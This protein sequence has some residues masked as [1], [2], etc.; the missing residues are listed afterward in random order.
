MWKVLFQPDRSFCYLEISINSGS[1]SWNHSAMTLTVVCFGKTETTQSRYH[2]SDVTPGWTNPYSVK[3][4]LDSWR[5][6][7]QMPR[8]SDTRWV[9]PLCMKNRPTSIKTDTLK[10]RQRRELCVAG[11][12]LNVSDKV[13][14]FHALTQGP[15]IQQEP[16]QRRQIWEQRKKKT[17]FEDVDSDRLLGKNSSRAHVTQ[18]VLFGSSFCPLRGSSHTV[19]SHVLLGFL[20]GRSSW[21]QALGCLLGLLWSV[22]HWVPEQ[23]LGCLSCEPG[24]RHGTE[25]FYGFL[26]FEQRRCLTSVMI[27]FCGGLTKGGLSFSACFFFISLCLRADKKL[28]FMLLCVS[29]WIHSICQDGGWKEADSWYDSWC[30]RTKCFINPSAPL[31]QQKWWKKM[32][33][34][35][36]RM[37]D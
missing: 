4:L 8:G 32:Q 34:T 20:R 33:R 24:D 7:V 22:L 18:K 30:G 26:M 21:R 6:W 3:M 2:W 17:Q 15:E 23:P 9:L 37:P 13:G 27:F 28:E 35:S 31:V 10:L 11:L 36:W 12:H 5:M 19:P 1:P 16:R 25:E 29:C 14:T